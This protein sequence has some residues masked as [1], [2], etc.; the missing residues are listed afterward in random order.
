MKQQT[1]NRKILL[2]LDDI[3]NPFLCDW[4]LMYVPEWNA[5]RNNV[6][7]VKTYHE[8]CD[9]IIKNGLPDTIAFDNDLGEKME[10]YDAAKYVV[11]YCM[12]NN[13]PLPNWEVQSANT[14]AKSNINGLLNN[15]LKFKSNAN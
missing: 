8:F 12:D 13:K 1:N 3:R 7:W 15:Y 2:W 4:L 6:V 9:W 14:V 10:G 5:D 11:E